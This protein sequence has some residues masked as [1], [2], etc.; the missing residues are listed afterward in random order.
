MGAEIVN[1]R[2]FRKQKARAAKEQQA[3]A[4][5]ATCGGPKH[6]RQHAEAERRLQE[7][8]LDSTK[9]EEPEAED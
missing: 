6:E 1:L 4:N 2:R 9:R 5:R 3:A 7:R 8:R